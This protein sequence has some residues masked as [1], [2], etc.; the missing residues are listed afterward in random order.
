MATKKKKKKKFNFLKLIIFV[1]IIYFICY[2]VFSLAGFKTKN[3]IIKGNNYL[4]DEEIIEQ[5]K[6]DNYPSYF[7]TNI[8][9]IKH[10]LIKN[11]MI[12]NVKVRRNLKMGYVIT[13]E[14]EKIL[15]KRRSDNKY[16][17]SSG[18]EVSLKNN[19]S[20]VATVINYIPNT[21]EKKLINKLGRIDLDVLNKISEIEYS[22]NKTDD[23]RFLLYMNDGNLCYITLTKIKELNYY[24]KIVRT[25]NNKRGILNLDSGMYFQKME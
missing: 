20:G 1:L 25:L 7:L 3:I 13:V 16:V 19:I 21:I 22:P 14:E 4:S 12:K 17:L 10:K 6:L 8:F 15:Y 18:K 9:T 23:E 2:F 24:I 5:A 11:D